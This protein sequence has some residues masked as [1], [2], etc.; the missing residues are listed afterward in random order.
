[1]RENVRVL[2]TSHPHAVEDAMYYHRRIAQAIQE[3]SPADAR[4]NMR[5]HLE[6]VRLELHELEF[7]IT[8]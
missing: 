7:P 5:M 4:E 6:S 8:T 3:A 1:M 2:V